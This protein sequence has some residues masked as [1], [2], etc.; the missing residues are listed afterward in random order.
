VNLKSAKA[1][2]TRSRSYSTLDWTDIDGDLEI[3]LNEQLLPVMWIE[4]TSR[5]LSDSSGENDK[6]MLFK[7]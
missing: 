4:L 2:W 1:F 6:C 7:V 5:Y 3:V